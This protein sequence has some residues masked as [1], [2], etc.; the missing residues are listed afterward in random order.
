MKNLTYLSV[1]ILA[2]LF[3]SCTVAIQR[4]GFIHEKE[5][6]VEV[7]NDCE[8]TALLRVEH[9]NG[10]FGRNFHVSMP[11]FS[12]NVFEDHWRGERYIDVDLFR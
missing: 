3:S 7:D 5:L 4:H 1:I 10:I 8:E 9:D 12:V 6:E 11:F 2:L